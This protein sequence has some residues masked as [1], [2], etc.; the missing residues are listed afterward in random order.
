MQEDLGYIGLV[1]SG[2]KINGLVVGG[3]KI[4]H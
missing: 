1:V 4:E 2:L 3:L